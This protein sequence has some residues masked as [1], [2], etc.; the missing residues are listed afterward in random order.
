MPRKPSSKIHFS[1]PSPKSVV[2]TEVTPKVAVSDRKKV[3]LKFNTLSYS[4]E[5]RANEIVTHS[6]SFE[7][8]ANEIVTLRNSY[9][10]K[11]NEIAKNI[12]NLNGS[13]KLLKIYKKN[14]KGQWGLSRSMYML[15]NKPK[16]LIVT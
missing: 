15:T 9:G 4:Y 6:A 12:F 11:A 5:K 1:S 14:G 16:Y 10:K 2:L 13:P 3:D 7:K 8:K